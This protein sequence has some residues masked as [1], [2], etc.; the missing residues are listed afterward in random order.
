[1]VLVFLVLLVVVIVAVV[2]PKT[3]RVVVRLLLVGMRLM[4]MVARSL[5][6]LLCPSQ[7]LCADPTHHVAPARVEVLAPAAMQNHEALLV[8]RVGRN[9]SNGYKTAI[10]ATICT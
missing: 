5:H 10:G 2:G 6:S 9:R 1:M 4:V 7:D 8:N 3:S